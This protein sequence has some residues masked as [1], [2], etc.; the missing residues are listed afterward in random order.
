VLRAGFSEIEVTPPV[1]GRMGRLFIGVLK[2]EGVKWPLKAR[3]AVFDDGR[4]R[5]GIIG[6]DQ[7]FLLPPAVA[8][9]RD[10]VASATELEPTEVMI[11]CSHTHNGPATMRLLHDEEGTGFANLDRL[12]DRLASGMKQALAARRPVRLRVGHIDAPGLT[13]NRRPI[14]RS[15]IG[16][17]VGTQGPLWVDAFLRMEGPAD[18]EL[19]VLLAENEAGEPVGGMVNYACHP[20]TMYSV[21]V[22]SA[23]FIGPLTD[24]L[25]EK[26]GCVFVFLQGASGNLWSIDMSKKDVVRAPGPEHALKMGTALAA[27]ANEALVGGSYSAGTEVGMARQVLR[28]PQRRPTREQ[29]KLARWYLEEAKPG[30]D[31]V[32]FTRRIYGHTYTMY[33]NSPSFTE[34][35]CRSLIGM[36][37]WQRLLGVREP[38][39]QVEIQ[40]MR[41]GDVA[42]VGYPSEIFCEFGLRTKAESP[43]AETFV[44]ELA[45]GWHGYVPTR[46][47]FAHGGYEARLG[48]PSRLVPEAGDRMCQA[49]LELLRELTKE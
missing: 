27:K 46:E 22:W 47:A 45:N 12:K 38:S 14:Y 31:Q 24:A 16:E 15:D 9:M 44:A 8:E 34:W 49:A 23:D 19:K 13:F 48:F 42:F 18:D 1:G 6:L 28:I 41:V 17:E 33:R 10:A 2:T 32:E 4:Q 21:P 40:A 11:A 26:H 29:V 20:T 25:K 7:S 37:E 5:V 35:F 43:F 39:E 30:V 36:W 3:I